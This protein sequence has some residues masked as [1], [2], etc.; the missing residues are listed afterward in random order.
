MIFI[1]LII[2]HYINYVICIHEGNPNFSP[3]Q[4]TVFFL[5][6]TGPLIKTD[7]PLK[8]IVW[9]LLR[10]KK[11][12]FKNIGRRMLR[13]FVWLFF[14]RLFFGMSGTTEKEKR[15]EVGMGVKWE[16]AM[17]KEGW[18]GWKDTRSVS[19]SRWSPMPCYQVNNGA[20]DWKQRGMHWM[21]KKV[22]FK[23]NNESL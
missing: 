9:D 15:G 13:I 3:F 11:K 21:A 7:L 12:I 8:I 6:K 23:R 5:S 4:K 18:R 19:R 22:W 2:V 10:S 14:F 20:L 17:G 1:A 16:G